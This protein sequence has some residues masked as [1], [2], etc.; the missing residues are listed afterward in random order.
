MEAGGRKR[1]PAL[2]PSLP[3]SLG[4]KMLGAEEEKKS[5]VT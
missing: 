5:N 4:M 1:R 3:L 2:L